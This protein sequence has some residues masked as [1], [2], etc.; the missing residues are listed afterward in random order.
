MSPKCTVVTVTQLIL[1]A[2]G[3][4][5]ERML[6]L[7]VDGQEGD[8]CSRSFKPEREMM[9]ILFHINDSGADVKGGLK[10]AE[11]GRGDLREGRAYE[12]LDLYTGGRQ[13]RAKKYLKGNTS[14]PARW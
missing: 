13:E 7:S 4:V 1:G 11:T 2:S 12:G 8:R 6:V 10:G 5:E 14:K 9:G 3:T